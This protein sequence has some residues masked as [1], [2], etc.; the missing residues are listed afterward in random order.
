MLEGSVNHLLSVIHPWDIL[1]GLTAE[2]YQ[3]KRK[4]KG[5]LY[6]LEIQHFLSVLGFI[7]PPQSTN[8]LRI[9]SQPFFFSLLSG[10]SPAI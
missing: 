5:L 9:Q 1:L 7:F 4:I 6:V 8:T 10:I 2:L 3:L